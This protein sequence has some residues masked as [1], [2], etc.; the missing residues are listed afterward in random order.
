MS[1]DTRTIAE[2]ML[3][4]AIKGANFDGNDFVHQAFE[5]GASLVISSN[6]DYKDDERV[7]YA[8]DTLKYLQELAKFHRAQMGDIPVLGLTGSNG[9]TTTKELLHQVLSAKYKVHATAGNYNNHIGVPLTLLNASPDAEIVIVEMGT[10]QPGDIEELCDIATPNFGVIT[11]IGSSHLEKLISEEGV[12]KEKSV[13]FKYVIKQNG[14]IFQNVGDKYL[15][16]FESETADTKL[17]PYSKS[18]GTFGALSLG[19]SD[20]H[21]LSYEISDPLSSMVYNGTS[22]FFGAYNLENISCVL[23]I[24]HSFDLSLST[25]IESIAAYEP[26][27]MRSQIILKEDK[28][29]I[30]DAYNANPSSM[31]AALEGVEDF[32]QTTFILGDMLE[33]GPLANAKHQ[34]IIDYLRKRHADQ[35]IL[36]G[37]H[38]KCTDHGNFDVF[39]STDDLVNSGLL[40]R[41]KNQHIL[42]KASRGI[43][44]EKTIAHID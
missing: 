22:N 38:F 18:Q 19:Q 16:T 23:T 17:I 6:A 42:I 12:Y 32:G 30:L 41:L 44:L 20:D 14:T 29:I 27:N 26:G 25:M 10:N 34:E 11:N 40:S 28:E 43:R 21:S 36:V 31:M 33:L 4:C 37:R 39:D 24:G 7:I 15:K 2:D 3:Y 1:I 35:V 5:N 8:T 9:K 13:L